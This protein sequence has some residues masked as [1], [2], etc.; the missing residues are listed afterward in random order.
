[1]AAFKLDLILRDF[2][3]ESQENLQRL[4]QNLVKLEEEPENL[5]LLADVFRTIHSIKGSAGFLALP[6]LEQ[7][8]HATEDVLAKARS[9]ELRLKE[10]QMTCV[11]HAIDSIRMVLALLEQSGAEGA[12]NFQFVVEHLQQ[13]SSGEEPPA[14]SNQ[15]CPAAAIAAAAKANVDHAPLPAPERAKSSPPAPRQSPPEKID[16]SIEKHQHPDTSED[17]RIRVNVAILDHLM[18]LTGELVLA[19]NQ[20]VRKASDSRDPTWQPIVQ[21]LHH[22][23]SDLQ[24]T[25]LKARM[26]EI[27]QVFGLF[28]RLVHDIS[29]QHGK[30]VQLRME[31]EKTELDRTLIEG[32]KEPLIHLIRNA[33]DHGIEE[34]E[35]RRQQG[36]PAAGT[37]SI[38]AYH[39]SGQVMITVSDDGAGIDV[40]RIKQQAL[41]QGVI[42][43]HQ[44]GDI[45]EY[46]LLEM[47]FRPGFS[48]AKT[49]TNISG[50]GV[51]MDVVK[52]HLNQMGGTIEIATT[53]GQGTIFHIRLPMTLAI[54]SG[55]LVSAHDRQFV[56]P[57]RN[58]EELIRLDQAQSL[59]HV[60]YQLAGAEVYQLRGELLPIVRL[61]SILQLPPRDMTANE[62]PHIVVLASG[63]RRFGLLVE[64]VRD[65][66]EI[67]V[68]PLG[69]HIRQV[70][71]YDGATILGDGN[72]ALILNA[73]GLFAAARFHLDEMQRAEQLETHAAQQLQ[74]EEQRQ[75]IVLFSAG[76]NEYYGVPLAFVERIETFPATAIE[77]SGGQEVL[78]YRGEVL[79]LM[80]LEPL[81]RLTSPPPAPLLSLLVF[82]IEKEIGLV[83]QR[84]INTVEISTQIDT[85]RFQQKG[86]LGSTIVNGLA[87]LIL[88][89]HGLIELAYP[90]WYQQ[91]LGSKLTEE[92][93][94]QTRVLL[95]ED[96]KFFMN[97]EQSYLTS[98]GYQVLTATHGQEALDV[99]EHQPVDVVVTDIDMPYCNGYELTQALKKRADWQHIPV[100]AVT[101]LSGEEDRRKGMAAGIDEYK[102]KLD[103]EEV[104]RALEQ[105]L[106]RTRKRGDAQ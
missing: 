1:M 7:L 39:E 11:L 84:V 106:L 23:V 53:P 81:L 18:N 77:T 100:M 42:A 95:V 89:I 28:P 44:A 96:S 86:V 91:L 8:A 69:R 4:D 37:I 105:L 62:N 70:A 60:I 20:V 74:N 34:P 73:R 48:T 12:L 15:N 13:I 102:I 55:L 49:V 22:V 2:L 83:V 93:R 68:K 5:E 40:E 57:Q 94:R 51:G 54:I 79:P 56:V 41:A 78:Q 45:S 85:K 71:C 99:L 24:E 103:R 16:D 43:P 82:S 17:V 33:I 58:L 90:N 65:T 38:R 29:Q 26:Q 25:M 64:N 104:L 52:R 98:A 30:H 75:T 97:I 87:V 27:R 10:R 80:R 6:H 47:I 32:L 59:Q 66:E 101:S 46:A 31:G 9:G 35:I 36:K 92:E 76:P 3:V 61:T 14:G 88:D 63:D 21:Q 72:V 19:R 50:R 67:V